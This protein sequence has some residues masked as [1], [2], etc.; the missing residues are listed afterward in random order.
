MTEITIRCRPDVRPQ[1]RTCGQIVRVCF[2]D[3]ILGTFGW[4]EALDLLS[5]LGSHPPGLVE[6]RFPLPLRIKASV[7]VR[8][9]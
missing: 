5:H 4:L 6:A 8:V 3:A 2:D 9:N 1:E 7:L